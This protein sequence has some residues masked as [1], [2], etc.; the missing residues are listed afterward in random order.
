[1]HRTAYRVSRS[2]SAYRVVPLY[3]FCTSSSK[4]PVDCLEIG[5]MLAQGRNDDGS[6][7]GSAVILL[8]PPSKVVGSTTFGS[9]FDDVGTHSSRYLRTYTITT[10]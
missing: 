3:R 8:M 5:A 7:L 1:M 6:S 2:E 10:V 9:S 4:F